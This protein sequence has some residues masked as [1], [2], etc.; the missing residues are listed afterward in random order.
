MPRFEDHFSLGLRVVLSADVHLYL[1]MTLYRSHWFKKLLDAIVYHKVT[2]TKKTVC[3]TCS[4]L[5]NRIALYSEPQSCKLIEKLNHSSIRTFLDWVRASRSKLLRL[6]PSGPSAFLID[7]W[8]T[9]RCLLSI[10]RSVS[11]INQNCE[12]NHKGHPIQNK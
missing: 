5:D 3:K 8:E 11:L 6:T 1:Y 12:S 4:H 9:R 7:C 10:K 2:T